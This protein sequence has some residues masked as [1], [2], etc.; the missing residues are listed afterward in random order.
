MARQ[1]LSKT[2]RAKKLAL[3]RQKLREAYQ[4][5][6]ESTKLGNR[7]T[8]ALEILLRERQINPLI[9]ALENLGITT[10]FS[11]KCCIRLVEQK[12]VAIIL[13]LMRN[14]NRSKPHQELLKHALR[15]IRNL[16]VFS[17]TLEALHAV[18]NPTAEVLMD[19]IQNFRDSMEIL[20]NCTQVLRR[21]HSTPGGAAAV[22]AIPDVKK[23][24]QGISAIMKRKLDV[25][26]KSRN[27]AKNKSS[28]ALSQ[29]DGFRELKSLLSC[30]N[31]TTAA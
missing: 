1:R 30:V 17:S 31:K 28:V 9:H 16:S 23:R 19:L 14:C 22:D 20:V 2:K 6:T 24:L 10:R 8:K 5:Q 13:E 11:Q 3:I 25:E 27:S 12:G 4:N 15:I 29:Q 21:M 18:G 26:E 7:T